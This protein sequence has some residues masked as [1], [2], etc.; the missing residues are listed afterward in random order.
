M[1]RVQPDR[2]GEIEVR[3]E[4]R[5]GPF[6]VHGGRRVAAHARRLQREQERAPI[7]Q[8]STCVFESDLDLVG[9]G[10][11]R[12]D[13]VDPGD[14]LG[15]RE[16]S[17]RVGEDRENIGPSIDPSEQAA[18]RAGAP[19]DGEDGPLAAH[20]VRHVRGRGSRRR[21]QVEPSLSFVG[22][23]PRPSY[24]QG[25]RDLA[26]AR[27]PGPQD[28]RTALDPSLA[29]YRWGRPHGPGPPCLT[30]LVSFPNEASR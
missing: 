29:V 14:A 30:I 25:G 10:D 5:Q 20:E 19:L 8:A 6:E 4:A 15:V 12:V 23:A 1:P 11:V 2:L 16:R 26:P 21:P 17:A 9:L 7:A 3:L 18:E 24:L 28:T 22:Q 13:A 27:V